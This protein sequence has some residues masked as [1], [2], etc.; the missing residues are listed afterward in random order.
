MKLQIEMMQ[1]GHGIGPFLGFEKQENKTPKSCCTYTRAITWEA[2]CRKLR[3]SL[4]VICCKLKCPAQNAWER[5]PGVI[6]PNSP[7]KV[8]L[9]RYR[10]NRVSAITFLH[11]C[12]GM[13]VNLVGESSPVKNLAWLFSATFANILSCSNSLRFSPLQWDS[14]QRTTEDEKSTRT[15]KGPQRGH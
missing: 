15:T 7:A 14:S 10:S 3:N 13:G 5:M 1:T 4:G 2:N 11:Q 12:D 6:S 8:T 9:L